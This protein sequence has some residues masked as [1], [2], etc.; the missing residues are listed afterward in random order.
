[1]LEGSPA[2]PETRP[3]EVGG[4]SET[5]IRQLYRD[6]S[7][8]PLIKLG[9]QTEQGWQSS[10]RLGWFTESPQR[11]RLSWRLPFRD[12]VQKGLR[13]ERKSTEGKAG[14]L[15]VLAGLFNKRGSR[16]ESRAGDREA[17]W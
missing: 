1:M 13:E 5:V 12:H 3:G 2:C 6:E 15:T 17:P 16:Q 10:I 7:L 9:D 14:I 11:S 4:S 8:Q